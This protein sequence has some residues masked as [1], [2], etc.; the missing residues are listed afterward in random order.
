MSP[1]Y[2]SGLTVA[3]GLTLSS[4]TGSSEV[5]TSTVVEHERANVL[6][7]NAN[8]RAQLIEG[9]GASDAWIIDP[10]IKKWINK[11][12]A[13]AIDELA[14]LLFSQDNGIGLSMWRF[15][16]GAG[17]AEQGA[18][19]R[20]P[21]PLRRAEL[22]IDRPGG[23]VDHAKQSGQVVLAQAAAKRGLDNIIAFVNSPPT[24][25]TK[26]G[27]AHPGSPRDLGVVGST[28][29][30]PKKLH[31][32]ARF[33]AD[34]VGYLRDI[35][36]LP[37]KYLSP[38]NEPTWRWA[39]E[40]QE[41]NRYNNDEVSAVYRATYAALGARG[42]SDAVEIDAGES[43]EYLAA[44]SD[45]TV[46]EFLGRPYSA[47]MNGEGLGEYRDYIGLLLGDS[48]LRDVVGNKI[49]LHGYWS[50]ALPER[51][52]DLRRLVKEEVAAASKDARIWMSELCVLG[53]AAGL[54]PFDGHGFDMNDIDY[55]LHIAR[56]IH[57]DLVDLGV[58]AWMWW[59]AV[60]A[61]DYKDGL[62]RVDSSLRAE[63]LQSSKL[64]WALGNFSRF[65]RPGFQRV[66]TQFSDE[67]GYSDGESPVLA[68]AYIDEDGK[69]WV[70]VV[71][72]L[73]NSAQV[74]QID[75]G[76]EARDP[77]AVAPPSEWEIHLTNSE[78]DLAYVR[79]STDGRITV[80][81]RSILTA[82]GNAT[83]RL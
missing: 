21:D 8:E 78:F 25:A 6:R 28:N 1:L 16:V 49:S 79:T 55:A 34:V 3:L 58:T 80:P 83:G 7:I 15:N 69:D 59:L 12:Q 42:L 56:I 30:E 9:F 50:D 11:H 17:S 19:S 37:I 76:T 74:I 67:V 13:D 66:S 51:I 57:H 65:I 72:N 54:R 23:T 10:M 14:D 5:E 46:A 41:G 47:G 81:A 61:Y 36:G 60:T 29:L 52:T 64:M 2:V 32:F 33:Q 40:T 4:C 70:M 18:A 63:T 48:E 45:E 20:I 22:F 27:L 44:L 38:I 35:K 75:P 77:V 71:I 26:N 53:P 43:V 82:I 68:S 62:L 31:D 73:S 24:W 39:D